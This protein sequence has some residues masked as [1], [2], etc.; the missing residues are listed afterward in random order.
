MWA[1]GKE[2]FYLPKKMAGFR[3]IKVCLDRHSGML[4]VRVVLFGFRMIKVCLDR[5]SGMLG[6]R[7]VAKV[8]LDQHLGML[9]VRVVPFHVGKS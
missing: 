5:H 6:V 1:I 7:V 9:G 8:C 2:S 4:G 3:M